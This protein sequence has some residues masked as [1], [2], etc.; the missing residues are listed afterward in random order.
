[1]SNPADRFPTPEDDQQLPSGSKK[2]PKRFVGLRNKSQDNESSTLVDGSIAVSGSTG[3]GSIED[4]TAIVP[5]STPTAST[6]K[7]PVT[8]KST[9]ANQIPSDI[10]NNDLLNAAIA[11][12]LPSNYNFEIH[13]SLWQIRRHGAKTVALQFPEGLLMFACTIADIL[14][15]FGCVE[16]VVMGDVTYGACCV[17]DFTARALGC[18]FLIHYGH[19]CLVPVDTTSIKTMYVF[20]DIAFDLDKFVEAVKNHLGGSFT[21][22]TT[23]SPRKRRLALVGTIQ[24]VTS[25]Q[26]SKAL[27]EDEFDV[28][29]PQAR[30]LSPGEILG[31]TAPRLKDID[32]LVYLADGRFHLEAIMIANPNLPA[33]RYDPYSRVFSREHYS[34]SAMR[35]RRSEAIA[36]AQHAK[37]WGL[38]MGTLGRQGSPKVLE[39]LQEQLKERGVEYVVILLSE[40]FPAK[41]GLFEGIDVFVQVACPRLSIDW[42]YA[43]GKPL[44]TPYECAVVLGKASAN[45]RGSSPK[46]VEAASTSTTSESSPASCACSNKKEETET[47]S[48]CCGN[49]ESC[50][51]PSSTS[52]PSTEEI[53][54]MDFYA[55]DSLGPWTPN[56]NPGGGPKGGNRPGGVTGRK[57]KGLKK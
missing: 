40:I 17:D 3:S 26:V 57:L 43:F 24:F 28:T 6:T 25:L 9:L 15:R 35:A 46:S 45:W 39:Y 37:K 14:E 29:V 5:S 7:R 49:K 31:C 47:P 53:Y 50:N 30:P 8:S 27:L 48:T 42:G 21:D 34:H 38:I 44:L 32:T 41:L 55:R 12:Q 54:P 10:L 36:R 20:V 16:T 18:D 56:H 13:K 22:P 51:P 11:H 19:S 33:Y 52:T 23:G 4:M 2:S 1:M